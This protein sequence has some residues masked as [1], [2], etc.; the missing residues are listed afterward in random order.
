MDKKFKNYNL[1]FRIVFGV[2]SLAVMGVIFF[3]SSQQGS[4][5][6]NTSISFIS[7]VLGESAD[8]AIIFNALVRELAH[9]AE[10][11]FLAFCVYMFLKTF[12]LSGFLRCAFTAIFSAVYAASDEIHQL[13]VPGRSGQIYDIV[14]DVLGVLLAV[15]FL[16]LF[17]YLG[18]RREIKRLFKTLSTADETVLKAFSSHITSKKTEFSVSDE[19]FK[20]SSVKAYEHKII[21]AVYDS[22]YKYGDESIKEKVP[23]M[24]QNVVSSATLQIKKA[25]AFFNVYG[26]LLQNGIKAVCVKGPMCALYYPVPEMRVAGDF[27]ILVSDENCNKCAEILNSNGFSGNVTPKSDNAFFDKNSGCNIELH[28]TLFPE[29]KSVYSKFNKVLSITEEDIIRC[30]F[31]GKEIYTLTPDKHILY[32]VLHAFKH[33]LVAGV[34]IRQ[35]CDISLFAKNNDIDWK[36]VFSECKKVNIDGFLN[37]ILLI[38]EKYFGFSTDEVKEQF[39][40]FNK[41]LDT[42]PLLCDIMSGGVYGGQSPER[43]H[44]GN[45]TFSA[46]N[47][48][49]AEE[50]ESYKVLFPSKA[51]MKEKYPV[52]KDSNFALVC[53]WVKRILRYFILGGSSSSA[54]DIA[55]KRKSVL[56]K[57]GIVD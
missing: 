20:E 33:F 24:K 27:D 36:Y 18:E 50:R 25:D 38:G 47:K 35:V 6:D 30:S 1:I 10:F 14:V 5:S 44:S 26:K 7:L 21:P 45:I 52:M 8:I 16:H 49:L 22:F 55:S 31:G 29:D 23:K 13:F 17:F 9:M 11:A 53:A 39:E 34:G 37:G 56:K 41:E 19:L 4:D 15:L 43:H 40:E 51:A 48:K 54:L 28:R 2:L 57:Y 46:Y 42:L 32:L 3:F 12:K